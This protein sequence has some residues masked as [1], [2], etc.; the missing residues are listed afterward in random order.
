[1]SEAAADLLKSR[2]KPLLLLVLMEALPV[3]A[4]VSGIRDGDGRVAVAGAVMLALFAGPCVAFFLGRPWAPLAGVFAAGTGILAMFLNAVRMGAVD[5]V[6]LIVPYAAATFLLQQERRL[7]AAPAPEPPPAEGASSPE[8]FGRWFKENVEAIVVAFIMALVI[9]CFC[10]EVFKIPSGSME[11]TLLGDATSSHM[12]EGNPCKFPEYHTSSGGDRIMVTKYYYLFEPVSRFDV[13]VFKFPLEL[14]RNFIKRVVGLPDEE[15]MV[16]HGN[17]Y[18][19]K[20]DDPDPRPRIQ[21]KPAATQ[22]SI[23]IDPPGDLN[24]S[25]ADR[26]V[27]PRHWTAQPPTGSYDVGENRLRTGAGDS[28]FRIV[29][30]LDDDAGH[31]VGDALVAFDVVPD[32]GSKVRAAVENEMGRFE[33]VLEA[34]GSRIEYARG[35]DRRT[36]PLPDAKLRAGRAAAVRFMVYDGQA[37]LVLDGRTHP[38]FEAVTFLDRALPAPRGV[39]EFGSSG[40]AT[41]S[42]LRIG[43]DIYYKCEDPDHSSSE[44]IQDGVPLRIGPGQYVMMGDNVGNSHDSRKWKKMTQRLKDGREIVYESQSDKTSDKDEVK[45]VIRRLGLS[46]HPQHYIK[47]DIN[48]REWVFNDSDLDPDA[49]SPKRDAF[50][51]VDRRHIIGKAFWVWW[52]AGRWFKM[53]R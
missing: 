39:I 41:F 38:A 37:V 26:D 13:V 47:A 1:M 53:I 18:A 12:R 45:D 52:P 43:R 49:P 51:F 40:P 9:R 21:R 23:W 20:S 6:I 28:R 4:I 31:A 46:V 48:G 25:F 32:E 15:F 2:G 42:K 34:G 44:N 3:A 5:W 11:P 10:I 36:H 33:L 14:S 17:V 7:R 50:P 22:D 8:T 29:R 19:R 27:F 24:K 30:K 35:D 16:W